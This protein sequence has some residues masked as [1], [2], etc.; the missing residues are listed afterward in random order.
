MHGQG[1]G[2][3]ARKDCTDRA[4]PV[5]HSQRRTVVVLVGDDD[6]VLAAAEGRATAT[7]GF[8]VLVAG[9]VTAGVVAG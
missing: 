6:N 4:T 3:G 1:A 2:D 8:S 7:K 5:R 9:A